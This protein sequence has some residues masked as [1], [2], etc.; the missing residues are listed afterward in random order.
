[1]L[2]SQSLLLT[3]QVNDNTFPNIMAAMAGYNLS[4]AMK[5]CN[6]YDANGLD[7]CKFIWN[8]YEEHGYVTAYGEDAVII[9]TFNYMKKGFRHSPTDYYLRPFL[10]GA[11][12]QL[13]LTVKFGLPHCLGYA[14]ESE[15]VYDYA[16]E[17]ARRYHNDTFFGFFW[18]NTHSH[19]DISQTSSMDD[20]L[21]DYL[22][23]LV[24]Q[25]TMENSIV[26][27]FSDHG[28]RFGPTRST[29]TG[30]Y[31][32]RLPFLFIWLP[33][34]VRD[35]HPEFVTALQENRN[36]LTSPYDLY[37]TLKHI[38]AI[39][40]RA[41]SLESLGG[42]ED[43]P[44]CQSMLSPVP[45]TRS[46]EDVG[47]VEHWCAC[48]A[49]NRVYKDSKKVRHVARS[50]VQ[51]LNNYM[52][53]FRNGSLAHLCEPLTLLHV[54]EAYRAQLNKGD[55]KNREIYLL[56]FVTMPNKGQFEAT[57][58]YSDSLPDDRN[59]EVTGSVSRLN[60]YGSQSACMMD[61]VI[62]KYCMCRS[63]ATT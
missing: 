52:A 36:R 39:S 19:T 37:L 58:T 9:N 18:T 5:K 53:T 4:T 31:E 46:C 25:G 8:L 28:M 62:K 42:A 24:A 43:C 47:I 50:V 60:T 49:Y 6:P 11:E 38:L 33:R 29:W 35:A 61:V 26:V 22:Q 44:Q 59:V 56:R 45:L 12:K 23:R 57:V 15:H 16:L 27:F 54:L 1:M 30:H 63:K 13:D 51:Y 34:F 17:F 14:T 3:P 41:S 48:W 10:S 21:K 2:I 7:K 32:E 55:T 20:Y 40:G